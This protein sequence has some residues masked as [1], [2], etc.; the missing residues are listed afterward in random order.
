MKMKWELDVEKCCCLPTG[1]WVPATLQVV[2]T[3]DSFEPAQIM[4]AQP[5]NGMPN[6]VIPTQFTHR[7]AEIVIWALNKLLGQ[8]IESGDGSNFNMNLAWIIPEDRNRYLESLDYQKPTTLN[9]GRYYNSNGYL[10]WSW[11]EGEGFEPC[12]GF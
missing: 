3:K 4:W 7:V 6:P 1:D 11:K 9:D 2:R 5:V 8:V 10:V 12:V